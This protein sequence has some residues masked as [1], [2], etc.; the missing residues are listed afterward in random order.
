V[1][2]FSSWGAIVQVR[3]EKKFLVVAPGRS[4]ITRPYP[5]SCCER[6]ISEDALSPSASPV[7]ENGTPWKDSLC[8]QSDLRT[9]VG[10]FVMETLGFCAAGLAEIPERIDRSAIR[11]VPQLWES[12]VRLQIYADDVFNDLVGAVDDC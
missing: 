9:L 4:S 5:F 6:A 7:D 11:H 1:P 12:L 10:G 2:I 8:L 3:C